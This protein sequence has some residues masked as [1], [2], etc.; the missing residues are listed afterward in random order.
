MMETRFAQ[1]IQGNTV[2]ADALLD[3]AAPNVNNVLM[4]CFDG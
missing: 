3:E 2:A 1:I 4:I